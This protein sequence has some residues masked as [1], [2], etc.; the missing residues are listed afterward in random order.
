MSAPALEEPFESGDLLGRWPIQLGGALTTY[1][2]GHI[3][4]QQRMAD[5]GAHLLRAQ[6]VAKTI[7][8]ALKTSVNRQRPDGT[9]YSFP[10][11]HTSASFA[12][13]TVLQQDFGWKVGLPAYG[14][15]TY[16]ATSR[17]Q[18]QKHFLSDVAFGAAIG[19][20]S[21]H[22]ITIGHGEHR[23]AVAPVAT[24]GGAAISFSVVG[25]R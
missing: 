6:V 10:S 11:G 21:G 22:A 12:T 25:D 1:T 13:A 4:G 24:P 19:I 8:F 15:A 14:L 3:T 2:L 23:L 20:V 5:V 18:A 9:P 16:I 7:T 17:L